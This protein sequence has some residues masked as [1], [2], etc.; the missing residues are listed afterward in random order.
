MLRKTEIVDKRVLE[1]EF[2]AI[3]SGVTKKHVFILGQKS[4]L[5]NFAK[6]DIRCILT[7]FCYLGKSR[8][9][10]AIKFHKT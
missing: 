8:L 7:T 4:D 3:S 6:T 1:K 9:M 5:D 10:S 2:H